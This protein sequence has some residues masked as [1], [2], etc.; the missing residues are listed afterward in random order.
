M[1]KENQ[2]GGKDLIEFML[3]MFVG[4]VAGFAIL[5]MVMVAGDAKA[6]KERRDY[7]KKID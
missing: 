1:I 2:Q 3:G 6:E 7:G 5:S 4:I